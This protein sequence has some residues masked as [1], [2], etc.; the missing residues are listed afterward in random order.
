MKKLFFNPNVSVGPF[1]FGT[2]REDI[3]KMMKRE[4]GSERDLPVFE[5]ENY[6]TPYVQLEYINNKLI[7]VSFIDDITRRDCEIYLGKEKIWPRTEKKLLPIFGRDS[8]VDIYGTY[9]HKDFSFIAEWDDRPPSLTIGC[10]GYCSELLENFRIFYTA[11]EM[12]KGMNRSECRK[13]MNRPPEVSRDGKTDNYPY[14]IIK[15]ELTS[16]TYDSDDRLIRAQ[17]T[18]SEEDTIDIL[19]K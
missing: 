13:L 1:V 16:L 3:W 7:S 6:Q 11:L 19:V 14:G 17:K 12:K 4:F 9:Y 18:F 10:Q 8:F 15:P 5:T 2:E